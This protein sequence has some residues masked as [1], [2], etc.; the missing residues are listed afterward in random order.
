MGRILASWI[1]EKQVKLARVRIHKL[2]WNNGSFKA[3]NSWERYSDLILWSYQ[4][5][6]F[7]DLLAYLVHSPGMGLIIPSFLFSNGN[8]LDL[9]Y[10]ERSTTSWL[11]SCR[12]VRSSFC[13]NSLFLKKKGKYSLQFNSHLKGCSIQW[14]NPQNAQLLMGWVLLILSVRIEK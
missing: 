3:Y 13:E 12:G 9:A 10:W 2:S 6:I 1:F 4:A 14:C 5:E 8:H 11:K 7:L